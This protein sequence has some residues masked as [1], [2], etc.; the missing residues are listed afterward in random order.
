MSIHDPTLIALQAQLQLDL[1]RNNFPAFVAAMFDVLHRERGIRFVRNWHIE[2]MCYPLEQVMG[3]ELNR[4][5]ITVPPRHMKTLCASVGLP[6]WMLGHRPGAKIFLVSYGK[7]L[8]KQN[9]LDLMRV[10]KSP[11]YRRLFPNTKVRMSGMVIRTTAGGIIRATSV[12][13]A[14]TG[15]GADLIV[16]DDLMKAN[17]WNSQ[18]ARDAAW[19]FFVNSVQTRLDN[20]VKAAIVAIQQ[21]LHEDDVAGHMIACGEYYHLNLPAIAVEEQR[22]PIGPGKI[23]IRRPGDVLFPQ[24]YPLERLE[25]L[26]R[27]GGEQFFSGQYQQ[28]PVPPGG[29]RLNWSHW[30]TY[31]QLPK[32]HE[33]E[34]VV[35]SWDT[36]MTADPE[37]DYSACTTWGCRE[38]EWYLLDVFRQKMNYGDLKRRVIHMARQ[39]AADRVIIESAASGIMLLRELRQERAVVGK[40]RSFGPRIDKELRF[41]TQIARLADG[42]FLLPVQAPWLAEF[43]HECLAFPRGKNDDMVD[44]MTQ[45]L[46]EMFTG[47]GRSMLNGEERPRGRVPGARRWR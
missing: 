17:D 23:H 31:D 44:S 3:G 32:R 35:Q 26:R 4:V 15:M 13:G 18:A 33:L 1:L 42:N 25:S 46:M 10:M 19:D 11:L 14:A 12:G 45:F 28:S 38:G 40:L 9:L 27:N 37:S 24:L 20:S 16:V 8:S 7:E 36:G 34:L 22:I 29:N 5:L 41:E 47:R 30:G 6:A 43:R 39:W 2:G 21:R